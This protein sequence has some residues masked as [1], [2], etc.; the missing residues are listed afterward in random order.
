M[1]RNTITVFGLA[2]AG[3][4]LVALI[5][6][7]ISPGFVT[8]LVAAENIGAKNPPIVLSENVRALNQAYVSVSK[9][10]IPTVVSISVMV[11]SKAASNPFMEEFKQFFDFNG[12]PYEGNQQPRRQEGGGSGV[13]ISDNG[14]ILTNNHVV[15]DAVEISVTINDQ[16]EY[17]AELIGADPLTDLAVIKINASGL[18][19]AHFGDIDKLKVGEIVIAVGNPLGLNSTVTSGIVSAVGRGTRINRDRSG[20]AVDNFIQTDAAINPGNSGGGLYN[21]EGSL[22]GINTAIATRTG[23]YIGYGFAIP[24][25]LAHAVALDLI[26][27]GKI[28]RGYIGVQIASMDEVMA[29][30]LGLNEIS[31][32]LVQGV[33]PDSP[34]EN[35]GIKL[36]DVI[37]ELDGQKIGTSNAL[38]SKI[39]LKRAGDDV[40]LILWRDGKKINKT[41]T[42]KARE[43]EDIA[44]SEAVKGVEPEEIEEDIDVMKFD[45]LGFTVES[46]NKATKEK[47]EVDDGVV[48]TEVERYSIAGKRNLFPNSVI[49]K[50]D[51]KEVKSVGDLKKIISSK[52]S[53]DALLLYV[54]YPDATRIVALEIP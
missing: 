48:V 18:P 17:K 3:A 34:A 54:K 50:A 38:Q 53:G 6:T 44:S 20:Y 40:E 2:G 46:L 14:Y 43:G 42:L 33:L 7:T 37:L 15:G 1:K 29:K 4:L 9:A 19:V 22:V 47:F 21:L 39:A 25:D 8:D 10:V 30:S 51:R 35:A 32:V 27:D 45:K 12:Q 11:E 5:I 28:D 13:I 41:V 23:T 26:D 24:V 16:K 49:T 31:G 36:G 52:D